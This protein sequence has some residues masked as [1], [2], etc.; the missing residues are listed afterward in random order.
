MVVSVLKGI[1]YVALK[2]LWYSVEG[3]LMLEDRL[4]LLSDDNGV[5]HMVNITRVNGQVHLFVVHTVSEP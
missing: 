4:E 2:E 5:M 1:R 3:A